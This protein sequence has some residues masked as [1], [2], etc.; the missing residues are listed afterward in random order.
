M[1]DFQTVEHGMS[2]DDSAVY[3]LFK[4]HGGFLIGDKKSGV[5]LA[6]VSAESVRIGYA[7][8]IDAQVKAQARR[9]S[10]LQGGKHR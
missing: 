9:D 8:Y 6:D 5:E 2:T 7:G 4:A 1:S 3:L 10:A